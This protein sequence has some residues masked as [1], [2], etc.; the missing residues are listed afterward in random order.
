MANECESHD[1]N[2]P[3]GH[4]TCEYKCLNCGTTYVGY[5][6]SKEDCIASLR[7]QLAE[8]RKV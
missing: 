1:Y 2:M 3:D 6:H 4:C 8:A 5:N 7:K